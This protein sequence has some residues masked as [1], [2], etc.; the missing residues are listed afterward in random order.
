M[1]RYQERSKRVSLMKKQE[2]E[3]GFNITL[4]GLATMHMLLFI[5][6]VMKLIIQHEFIKEFTNRNYGSTKREI[7]KDALDFKLEEEKVFN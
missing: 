6:E 3:E 4:A 7:E 1:K 2:K 5:P